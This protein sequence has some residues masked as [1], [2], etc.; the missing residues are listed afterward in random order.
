VQLALRCG[1]SFTVDEP[2]LQVGE[3]LYWRVPIWVTH[4][5]QGKVV[6]LGGVSVDA[7]TGEVLCTHEQLR[8]LKAA[9]QGV[10][11]SLNSTS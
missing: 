11:Q 9:A 7:Q 5:T 1:Q 8:L 2:E 4:P 3:R 10:L 6:C